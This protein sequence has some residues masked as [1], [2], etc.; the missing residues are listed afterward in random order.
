[1]GRGRKGG[2]DGKEG[3]VRLEKGKRVGSG[4]G[5]VGSLTE[6][7]KCPQFK[8]EPPYP[9]GESRG[10]GGRGKI[11]Y[12]DRKIKKGIFARDQC[13]KKKEDQDLGGRLMKLLKKEKEKNKTERGERGRRLKRIT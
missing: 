9:N 8:K 13:Q 2:R 7:G 4:R 1:L 6:G 3:W 12:R 11:G 10:L 5:G